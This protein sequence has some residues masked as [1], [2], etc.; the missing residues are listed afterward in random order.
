MPLP[1]RHVLVALFLPL[2]AS[3]L[4]ACGSSDEPPPLAESA[5]A[6][7]EPAGFGDL[8][9]PPRDERSEAERLADIRERLLAVR[10]EIEAARQ[11]YGGSE[12]ETSRL[13]AIQG[14]IGQLLRGLPAARPD[15]RETEAADEEGVAAAA[16][17]DEAVDRA[18]PGTADKTAPDAA[19]LTA[20]PRDLDETGATAANETA[21]APPLG[22]VAPPRSM[23]PLA[24]H[25]AS[26]QTLE[27]VREGWRLLRA[28]HEPVLGD[29]QARVAR[30]NVPGRGD[31]YRLYAG[32][33]AD[34]MD[35]SDTCERFQA[36]GGYCRVV[37]FD[38]VPL[39]VASPA[40]AGAAGS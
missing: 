1:C 32:P 10:R 24:L 30:T 23:R 36:R 33:I 17:A 28:A 16:A 39:D 13:L 21:S 29:L 9:E 22:T 37:P 18:S 5:T 40:P 31:Y 7:P 12:P 15:R 34:R 2:A 20:A 11:D 27:Q 25:L 26:Y 6:P 19:N 8:V 14:H 3:G 35:A 4:A 38:G